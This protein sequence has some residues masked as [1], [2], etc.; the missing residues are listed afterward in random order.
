MPDATDF[1]GLTTEDARDRLQRFGP[2][3]PAPEPSGHRLRDI[4][5]P[6]ANPLVL[7][8][9]AAAMIS[10]SAG[11]TVGAGIILGIVFISAVI[12]HFQ[13]TR[14]RAA[15][16]RLREGVAV[17]ATVRRDGAWIEIVRSEVVPGDII[18]LAAGDLV[19]A[20]A[21]LLAA[22]DL[23]VQQSALTGESMPV[24][25]EARDDGRNS[26]DNPGRVF[27]GTS[28][29]SGMATAEVRTTG[30]ATAFG[31]IAIRL[32]SRPAETEFDRGTRR[33]GL[34][35]TQTVLVLVLL[36]FLTNAVQKRDALESLL[37]AVALAVG[38][39]PEFLPMITSVTLAAGAVRM[40]HRKVVVKHLAAL[41]N[42]GSIDILCSDKTG[43]LTCG[44]MR[45]ARIVDA[46]GEPAETPARLAALNSAFETGIRS[47]LDAAILRDHPADTAAFRKRDEV[48]FDFER[49]RV[50]V[51]LDGPEGSR[52][53]TKGAPES[54]L[55]CCTSVERASGS[56]PM[57]ESVAKR[58]RAICDELGDRGYRLI[59]VASKS[60]ASD[61]AF[62]VR[63]EC[64]LTFHGILAF[65]DP[66]RDD[67]A[68]AI[69]SLRENGVTIRIL[70]GDNE[71]VTRHVC[72]QV[73][74]S[75]ENVVLG[76]EIDAMT[77]SALGQVAERETAFARLSP[78]QKNRLL[79]ALQARGH[80]VG[81]L[82][83]GIN[84][85]PSLHAADVGITVSTAVDVAK[86]AA[87]VVLLDPGL[88]VLATGITEGRRA[89]GNVMKY[90]VMGTSSNF[91]NMLSMAA[92]TAFL[93]FL[94]LL[95]LQVL[96]NSLLYDMAQLTIPT[97]SVDAE[98]MRKPRRWD[99]GVI[100]RSM[101]VLG[102]ISSLFDLLTFFVLY[103]IFQAGE[104]QFHTGWFVESLAT[105]TLVLLV[106]RTG[107]NP[108]RSRPSRPL[109]FT[110][111]T[112]SM[113]GF[114][115]PYSP[116]ATALGFEPMPPAFVLFVLVV[117]A[118]YLAMT[119]AAKR[120]VLPRA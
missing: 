45:L 104:A 100:R 6:F 118:A 65:Q 60:V 67:A 7:I 40:A 110:I 44:E 74:L 89:F 23:H 76:S 86:E 25:K 114:V 93:P 98:F 37:F 94:P 11:D 17:T 16:R 2:N 13:T 31:E 5:G 112:V 19:P 95:P 50:S 87:E 20:D 113:I 52:F 8:L 42:L 51:A 101:L 10:A 55:A 103:R 30:A 35:I 88:G 84:D 38:L 73:G 14:S 41:Q 56:F 82:G 107:G 111:L 12:D 85:A 15:M 34:F 66:P 62:A 90:L 49:R 24:E 69:R 119:Q 48:P 106:I 63:D 115:L 80:V 91:G 105:Q 46:A 26:P 39:T 68:E 32:A 54:I 29:V 33:F 71:R 81:F 117:T 58:I 75:C 92:A 1:E 108:L 3:V 77:D 72:E 43:T 57:D 70:T 102:P 18:R 47:P 99:L 53:I 97:D 83:D 79:A 9:I 64:D 21:C 116:L 22:R 109:L 96:L 36:V 59:A 28:V 120:M 27:F 78:G 4:V 61:A